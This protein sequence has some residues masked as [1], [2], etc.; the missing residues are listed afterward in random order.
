MSYKLEL[1][2]YCKQKILQQNE[3]FSLNKKQIIYKNGNML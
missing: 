1:I 2:N 3:L